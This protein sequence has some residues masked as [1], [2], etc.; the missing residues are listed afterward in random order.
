MG[1]HLHQGLHLHRDH[2]D[3]IRL[4]GH[5]LQ[6]VGILHRRD[7]LARHQGDLVLRL[8]RDAVLRL[9]VVPWGEEYFRGSEQPDVFPYPVLKQ[10]GCFRDAER[11][12]GECPCLEPSRT[13]CFR[14]AVHQLQALTSLQQQVPLGLLVLEMVL[15]LG[16]LQP[17]LEASV[18]L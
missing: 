1:L 14:G 2:R 5:L 13:G 7:D 8:R 4:L 6:D 11:Q 9:G 17:E 18:P 3:G 16:S 12:L 15:V 10:R